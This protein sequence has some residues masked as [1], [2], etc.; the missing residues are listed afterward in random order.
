M[1]ELKIYCDCGSDKCGMT[2]TVLPMGAHF[3]LTMAPRAD[4]PDAVPAVEWIHGTKLAERL[5][6]EQCKLLGVFVVR[7]FLQEELDLDMLISEDNRQVLLKL[8]RGEHGA[9]ANQ[10][11]QGTSAQSQHA[12]STGLASDHA[13]TGSVEVL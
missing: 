6:G 9:Q 12:G 11:G 5:E 2:L 1:D 3:K 8:A 10:E 13:R 7:H 4:T